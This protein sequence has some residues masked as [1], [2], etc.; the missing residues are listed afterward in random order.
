MQV[1]IVQFYCIILQFINVVVSGNV[2][3]SFI[4]IVIINID[5]LFI[6][7]E[8]FNCIEEVKVL[9]FFNF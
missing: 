6:Y 4:I 8:K 7:Y 9:I 3:M 1:G 2:N 5:D